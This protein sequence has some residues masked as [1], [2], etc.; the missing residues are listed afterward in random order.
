MLM[1]VKVVVLEVIGYDG[2]GKV[3]HDDNL[4]CT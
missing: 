3:A 2:D 4:C 1:T